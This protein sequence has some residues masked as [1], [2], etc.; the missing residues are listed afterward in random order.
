MAQLAGQ[1]VLCDRHDVDQPVD[2]ARLDATLNGDLLPGELTTHEMAA[3]HRDIDQRITA[4]NRSTH[5]GQQL[6][7]E[8]TTTVALDED[9][10]LT[11]HLPDGTVQPLL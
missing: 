4:R 2:Q 5:F 9:G 3:L 11:R 10:R 1:P 8:G 6:A 7:A